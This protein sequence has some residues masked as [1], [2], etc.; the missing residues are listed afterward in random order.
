M[1]P[2]Y[3]RGKPPNGLLQELI[4]AAIDVNIHVIVQ[5]GNPAPDDYYDSFIKIGEMKIIP[6]SLAEKLAPSARVRNRL[7]PSI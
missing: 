1:Q 4:E 2:I 6:L 3:I 7:A 5:S